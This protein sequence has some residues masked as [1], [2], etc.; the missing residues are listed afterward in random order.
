MPPPARIGVVT[1][2]AGYRRAPTLTRRGSKVGRG[3]LVGRG[4]GRRTLRPECDGEAVNAFLRRA[5]RRGRA[6]HR[7]IRAYVI[8]L[9]EDAAPSASLSA[10]RMRHDAAGDA[11]EFFRQFCATGWNETQI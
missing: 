10:R 9:C 7:R 8:A 5:K 2:A 1:T 4:R 3:R 6:Q 11:N